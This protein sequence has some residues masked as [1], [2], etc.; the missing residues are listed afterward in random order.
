MLLDDIALMN[1][2][3]PLGAQESRVRQ[4]DRANGRGP[5]TRDYGRSHASHRV[6]QQNRSHKLEPLD[7]SNDSACVILVP[8]PMEGCA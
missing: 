7:E 2:A 6:A 5:L 8:I 4:D 1:F 3:L